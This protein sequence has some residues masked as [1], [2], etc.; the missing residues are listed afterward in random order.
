MSEQETSVGQHFCFPTTIYMV[1]LN[2]ILWNV[3][4][5]VIIKHFVRYYNFSGA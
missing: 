3:P 1:L 4:V 5:L 2:Y